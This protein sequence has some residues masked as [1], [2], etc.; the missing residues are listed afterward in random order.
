MINVV[1]ADPGME[2]P[3][4]Y[5][6]Q[7]QK[8]NVTILKNIWTCCSAG[9]C[10]IAPEIVAADGIVVGRKFL[11]V[12]FF[13]DGIVVGRNFLIDDFLKNILKTYKKTTQKN[14]KK[15]HRVL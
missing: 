13:A 4:T 5:S 12:D 9:E 7:L 11:M 2:C 3:S 10:S 8:N 1:G 15:H 14:T 6:D